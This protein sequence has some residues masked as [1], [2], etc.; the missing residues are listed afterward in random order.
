MICRSKMKVQCLNWVNKNGRTMLDSLAI[1]LPLNIFFVQCLLYSSCFLYSRCC[2]PEMESFF[3]DFGSVPECKC[4]VYE[5][6]TL[7]GAVY[8]ISERH[9]LGNTEK[10]KQK[11]IDQV[12]ERTKQDVSASPLYSHDSKHLRDLQ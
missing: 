7:C 9:M 5:L 6:L 11:D 4:F 1:C 2:S 3:I 12:C 10:Y 8:P